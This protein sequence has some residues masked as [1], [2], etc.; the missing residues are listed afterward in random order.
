MW[1][2]KAKHHSY[3]LGQCVGGRENPDSWRFCGPS[4]PSFGALGE[5]SKDQGLLSS[6]YRSGKDGLITATVS[7]GGAE[8]WPLRLHQNWDSNWGWGGNSLGKPVGHGGK[9]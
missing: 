9:V 2:M 7:R 5:N 1:E 6:G 3:D 4:T 8:V